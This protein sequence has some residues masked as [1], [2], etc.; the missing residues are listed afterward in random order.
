MGE[1]KVEMV[2]GKRWR[3]RHRHFVA[4]RTD[5]NAFINYSRCCIDPKFL[6]SPFPYVS[7]S[8]GW[9]EYLIHALLSMTYANH[10]H[11]RSYSLLLVW[12]LRSTLTKY[13]S[14]SEH[15]FYLP[16]FH[17]KNYHKYDVNC[18]PHERLSSLVLILRCYQFVEPQSANKYKIQ[19]IILYIQS[20]PKKTLRFIAGSNE[21]ER[22]GC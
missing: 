21:S 7:I 3:W 2:L 14:W 17:F 15:F 19:I 13:F 4:A 12:L 20:Y 18:T 8:V 10:M 11:A 5:Q 16:L 22:R 1:R 9:H 6:Y